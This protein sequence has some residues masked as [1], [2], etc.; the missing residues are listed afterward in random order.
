MD[1]DIETTLRE[2][3]RAGYVVFKPQLKPA[4]LKQG[5]LYDCQFVPA[6]T[7]VDHR[8]SELIG[9]S[10]KQ[11]KDRNIVPLNSRLNWRTLEQAFLSVRNF[12][13]EVWETGVYQGVTA[14][15]LANC[16]RTYGPSNT[17]LRLFDTFHG[18]P[19]VNSQKDMHR[20]GNFADTSVE[21]V[22]ELVGAG[23]AVTFHEGIIPATFQGLEAAR[24]KLVH[25]DLDL[26][27][28]YID[29]LEFCYSRMERGIFVFD[30]YGTPSCP[31]A[32]EAVDHFF[33]GRPE[34]IFC[35]I[36]GQAI[37]IKW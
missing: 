34:A 4:G 24:L 2:L 29:T 33:S 27:Q 9:A 23:V 36:T 32:L 35:S 21:R 18:M 14:L 26:Y 11:I 22:R 19:E 25:I 28:S 7:L 37:A 31:G 13:G 20:K 5:N 17:V 1:E 3:R 8:R 10:A 16:I 6:S 12:E 15:V 30:D